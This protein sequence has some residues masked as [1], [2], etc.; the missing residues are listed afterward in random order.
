M[1]IYFDLMIDKMKQNIWGPL[2]ILSFANPFGD[3]LYKL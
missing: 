2:V 1:C 3:A